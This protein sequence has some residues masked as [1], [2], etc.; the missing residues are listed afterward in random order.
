[1]IYFLGGYLVWKYAEDKCGTE[2]GRAMKM[3]FTLTISFA[4][5]PK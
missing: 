2:K 4:E 5:A 1:M 3:K